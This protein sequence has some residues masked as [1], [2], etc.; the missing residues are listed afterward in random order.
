MAGGLP[1]DPL[2]EGR[3]LRA[4]GD[5]GAA[6][7]AF[8]AALSRA[9]DEPAAY[10]GLARVLADQDRFDAALRV[11]AVAEERAPGGRAERERL[12]AEVYGMSGR[13]DEAIARLRALVRDEPELAAAWQ[14]LAMA[15]LSS[16]EPAEAGRVL[17]EAAGRFPADP[18]IWGT[19]GLVAAARGDAREA[20]RCYGEALARAEGAPREKRTLLA[21]HRANA[22]DMAGESEAAIDAYRAIIAA[23]EGAR[24]AY[25]QL[26]T[27]LWQKRRFGAAAAVLE[28]AIARWPE[29]HHAAYYLGDSRRMLG[30]LDEAERTFAAAAARWP[31]CPECLL[32]LAQV[33]HE[34]GRPGEAALLLRH[35]LAQT[36]ENPEAIALFADARW[37]L[38]ERDEARKLW[39]RAIA[40]APGELR[41]IYNFALREREDGRLEAA[42]AL[43]DRAVELAP[44]FDRALYFAAV[45]RVERGL[46]EEA[47]GF[48]GRFVT[49]EPRSRPIV[50]A[51]P[52]LDPLKS[53]DAYRRLVGGSAL[54]FAVPGAARGALED[55]A[56]TLPPAGAVPGGPGK[57]LDEAVAAAL[58]AAD[59]VREERGP[60]RPPPRFYFATSIDGPAL[61][62]AERDAQDPIGAGRPVATLVRRPD[63]TYVLTAA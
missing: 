48:L 10:L 11:L 20:V 25:L 8:R 49:A 42:T 45:C 17:E 5:L 47:L 60:F 1:K 30:R 24:L 58:S 55:L 12:R 23:D 36:P 62:I 52:A 26:G 34:L 54:D 33:R 19:R 22:L 50:R 57:P 2:E 15:L 27:A 63:G 39:E 6:E 61:T 59:R 28:D 40:L 35:V 56:R 38:G 51:D 14:D 37:A 21:T 7:A 46:R 3:R 18:D 4:E 32:G 31:E 53:E 44:A 43:F 41:H 13:P 16:G 29:E 9:P